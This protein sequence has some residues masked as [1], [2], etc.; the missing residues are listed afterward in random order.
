V[1]EGEQ[2][3]GRIFIHQGDDSTFMAPRSENVTAP[4]YPKR[5]T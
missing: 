4:P 2:L 3:H 1:L 5:G